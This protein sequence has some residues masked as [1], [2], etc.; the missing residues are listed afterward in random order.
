MKTY[1]RLPERG[2]FAFQMLVAPHRT[3]GA[4]LHD[5][6]GY[7]GLHLSKTMPFGTLRDE[8][9]HLYS[10]VRSVNSPTGTPNATTFIYQ[11]TRLDGQTLHM[12][13]PRMAA[14]AQT[15]MPTRALDADTVRWTSQPDEAGNPW[16]LEA[17]GEHVRWVEEG[18]MDLTGRNIGPGMQW[19]LPG[20]DW[21]TFYLSQ[22]YD[23][24]G[25]CEGRKVKGIMAVEQ[26]YMAEGGQV[27]AKKCLIVNNKKHVIWCAFATVYTDGT[28]D[29]GTF[30]VGH[31]NLGFA[32]LTN[33][34]GEVR[35]TTDV[36]AV[37]SR[38]DGDPFIDT[39]RLT[40]EG[41]EVWEFLPDP[42][43]RMVDF[44]GGHVPTAQQEGRWQRVGEKRVADHW[45]AWGE[46]DRRNGTAR[47]VLGT[48]A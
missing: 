24:S 1:P 45:F 11:S 7:F 47:N 46:G 33:E 27:H 23:L 5:L 34:K 17:S 35:T 37:V 28:I 40:V 4:A 20:T 21:G 25:T 8:E 6:R 39:V 32:F 10:M 3:T 9:G 22:L 31:E 36:E 38:K 44:L 29:A 19:L 16:S 12:D 30:L 43:G 42:K 18:L 41:G 14:Q 48:A 15:L 26:S 13:K 2:D